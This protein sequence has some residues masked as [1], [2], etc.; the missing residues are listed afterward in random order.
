MTEQADVIF[1]NTKPVVAKRPRSLSETLDTE[2]QAKAKRR[3]SASPPARRT[4]FDG[5]APENPFE[6]PAER[7]DK[8]TADDE[9]SPKGGQQRFD[10]LEAQP[11]LEAP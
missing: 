9:L 11:L 1:E 3:T 8:N 4:N 5:L 10:G 2:N 7:Q 6:V